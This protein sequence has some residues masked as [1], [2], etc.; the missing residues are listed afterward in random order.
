MTR[1]GLLRSGKSHRDENFPVASWLIHPRHRGLILAFYQFV[2]TADDIADH[3]TLAAGEKLAQLDQLEADLD[4]KRRRK[5]R[6]RSRLRA[7]L[8]ARGTVAAPCQ[9]SAD[10]VPNGRD[11]AALSR[12]GRSHRL[13]RLFG[14]AGRSVR[15]RRAWRERADVAG[16]TMRCA[17]LCKSSIICRIAGQGLPQPQSRLCSARRAGRRG[18]RRCGN[19]GN[20]RI[21]R[22]ARLPAQTCGSDRAAFAPKR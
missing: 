9:G 5:S 19:W 3:A 4:G 1:A 14:D 17:R 16:S 2:R 13:L 12:L 8:A 18:P 15:P 21:A 7:A 22:T 11:Q 20:A 6:R 10:R